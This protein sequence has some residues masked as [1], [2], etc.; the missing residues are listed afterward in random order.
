MTQAQWASSQLAISDLASLSAWTNTTTGRIAGE[1]S[2]IT[3]GSTA[4]WQLTLA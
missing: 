2:W 1:Q 4:P 3:V